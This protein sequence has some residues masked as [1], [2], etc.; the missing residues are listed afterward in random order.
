MGRRTTGAA[1]GAL[2][3][4]ALAAALVL[5]L[6]LG[7]WP[8]GVLTE[9]WA[10]HAMLTNVV[11]SLL[12]LLVG[13]TL[14]EWWIARQDARRY[15][16]IEVTAY[17]AVAR[18]PLAARRALWG[19]LNGGTGSGDADFGIREHERTEIEAAFARRGLAPASELEIVHRVAPLPPDVE[20]LAVLIGDERWRR[21]ALTVIRR[22][23][24]S[25]RVITARWAQVMLSAQR[26][27]ETL[28]AIGVVIEDLRRVRRILH[29]LSGPGA[30][31]AD[32]DRIRAA[33]IAWRTAFV[34][35]AD[36]YEHIA[37]AAH[38]DTHENWTE[39]LI[40]PADLRVLRVRDGTRESWS[41]VYGPDRP[42][43]VDLAFLEPPEDPQPG[44]GST[45]D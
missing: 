13:A 19:L 12:F 34:H 43:A 15:R 23:I 25:A 4:G 21:T 20:R 29:E 33:A 2:G 7:D 38:P 22:A 8:S 5:V 9:F 11:S 35:A 24:D 18:A 37:D 30:D 28:G 27:A 10:E 14:V 1:R 45:G 26:S 17:G 6:V 40:Q 41:P 39:L 44:S 31:P 3:I 32:V 36:A 42:P 16:I